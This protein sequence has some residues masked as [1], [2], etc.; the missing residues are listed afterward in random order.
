MSE[1]RTFE[2]RKEGELVYC[3]LPPVNHPEGEMIFCV[4]EWYI[5]ELIA[6]LKS[7]QQRQGR[8]R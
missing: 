7:F 3:W 8:G 1:F 5:E 2:F 4:H 6:D